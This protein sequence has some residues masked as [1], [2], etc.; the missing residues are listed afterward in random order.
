MSIERLNEN[1]VSGNFNLLENLIMLS[2]HWC[3]DTD[4]DEI[5]NLHVSM[6]DTENGDSYDMNSV[7]ADEFDAIKEK[8]TSQYKSRSFYVAAMKSITRAD[9]ILFKQK[10][11]RSSVD[12]RHSSIMNYLGNMEW[13]N[14]SQTLAHRKIKVVESFWDER[15]TAPETKP[16]ASVGGHAGAKQDLANEGNFIINLLLQLIESISRICDLKTEYVIFVAIAYRN[17][18]QIKQGVHPN[19]KVV[20]PNDIK[21][22]ASSNMLDPTEFK[23]VFDGVIAAQC[24]REVLTRNGHSLLAFPCIALR[25]DTWNKKSNLKELVEYTDVNHEMLSYTSKENSDIV[26]VEIAKT[27]IDVVKLCTKQEEKFSSSEM[28]SEEFINTRIG[29][30]TKLQLLTGVKLKP[31]APPS[32]LENLKLLNKVI[33]SAIINLEAIDTSPTAEKTMSDEERD[34]ET[35]M[36]LGFIDNLISNEQKYADFNFSINVFMI[37]TKFILDVCQV[38]SRTFDVSSIEYIKAF[39][40]KRVKANFSNNLYLAI[41]DLINSSKIISEQKGALERMHNLI[42]DPEAFLQCATEVYKSLFDVWSKMFEDYPDLIMYQ[43]MYSISENTLRVFINLRLFLCLNSYKNSYVNYLNYIDEV[44]NRPE[45]PVNIINILFG[46]GTKPPII[47]RPCIRNI[48]GNTLKEFY[49]KYFCDSVAHPGKTPKTS[50]TYLFASII[51]EQQNN[52]WDLA[53]QYYIHLQNQIKMLIDYLLNFY[54]KDITAILSESDISNENTDLYMAAAKAFEM[55]YISIST[56]IDPRIVE[57]LQDA[58]LLNNIKGNVLTYADG[59]LYIRNY[60]TARFLYSVYGL[61]YN[62]DT[63]VV[64][65]ITEEEVPQIL[66]N[67]IGG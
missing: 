67:L 36:F 7:S 24:V 31:K 10:A 16:T 59:R 6:T 23:V 37:L 65:M 25:L 28:L 66:K 64:S 18:C 41:E 17:F 51:Q 4:L 39:D 20:F 30:F 14:F 19:I 42:N 27:T 62:I 52:I 2:N 1:L 54:F 34:Y 26:E 5:E 61:K 57:R 12:H 13:E 33:H 46:N 43:D 29:G 50:A 48:N 60:P 44:A 55:S 3:K 8:E 58:Q 56:N 35:Y 53:E 11:Q 21:Y 9:D 45:G 22:S 49:S 63:K 47:S 32:S 38:S 40:T 15:Y